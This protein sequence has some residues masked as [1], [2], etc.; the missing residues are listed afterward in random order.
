MPGFRSSRVLGENPRDLALYTLA[1]TLYNLA[2]TPDTSVRLLEFTV[3]TK[4]SEEFHDVEVHIA[5]ELE[6]VAFPLRR[7]QRQESFRGDVERV[8]GDQ[9]AF[10]QQVTMNGDDAKQ[11]MGRNLFEVVPAE[12]HAGVELHLVIQARMKLEELSH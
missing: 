10:H 9:S 3:T 5:K 8:I 12:R 1:F 6:N 7:A 2:L 11:V 4:S